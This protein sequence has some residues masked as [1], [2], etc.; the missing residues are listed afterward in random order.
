[1]QCCGSVSPYHFDTNPDPVSIFT[2]PEPLRNGISVS[3][4]LPDLPKFILPFLKEFTI[5]HESVDN[6]SL[7]TFKA[8]V[9]KSTSIQEAWDDE[10][11]SKFSLLVAL[12]CLLLLPGSVPDLFSQFTKRISGSGS[13]A[14]LICVTNIM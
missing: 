12:G 14:T 9:N 8:G 4:S 3:I 13:T 5:L 7:C 6:K 2:K 1:M 11:F 10:R